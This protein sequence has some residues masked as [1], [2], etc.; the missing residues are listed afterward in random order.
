MSQAGKCHWADL[1][2]GEV[3]QP[4]YFTIRPT[5]ALVLWNYV[6]IK[7]SFVWFMGY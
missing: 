2:L 3:R 5:G 6:S 1:F 4:L 7:Y